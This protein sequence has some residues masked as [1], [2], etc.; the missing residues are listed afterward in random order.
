VAVSWKYTKGINMKEKYPASFPSFFRL[1]YLL[2]KTHHPR[3]EDLNH[4]IMMCRWWKAPPS[5]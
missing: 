1:L 4:D 5:K 3:Y 2:S